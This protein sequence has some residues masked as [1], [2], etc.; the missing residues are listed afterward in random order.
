MVRYTIEEYNN[1]LEI[2]FRV[3]RNEYEACR[4][5]KAEYPH[6]LRKPGPQNFQRL[7]ERFESTGSV[8]V[9]YQLKNHFFIMLANF[10]SLFIIITS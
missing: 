7:V 10:F 5:Y 9:N 8:K 6:V 4:V 1:M 2:Y 3:Q